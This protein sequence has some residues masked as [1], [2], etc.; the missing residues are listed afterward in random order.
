MPV[1]LRSSSRC[2]SE[3][4]DHAAAD[5]SAAQQT[6]AHTFLAH[7]PFLFCLDRK[8]RL[9]EKP[10]FLSTRPWIASCGTALFIFAVTLV[11][12]S[13]RRHRG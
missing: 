4:V 11:F 3:D 13:H 9:Y 2:S 8:S 12:R 10:G 6:H 7:H 1:R 5:G